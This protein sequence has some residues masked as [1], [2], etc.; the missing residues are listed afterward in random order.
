MNSNAKKSNPRD[1]NHKQK[2][3]QSKFDGTYQSDIDTPHSQSRT[4][5]PISRN[6]RRDD[7]I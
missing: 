6:K 7:R 5:D 2:Y 3:G 1:S 4:P